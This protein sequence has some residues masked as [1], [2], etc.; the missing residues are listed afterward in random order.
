MK[1]KPF[2]NIDDVIVRLVKRYRSSTHAEQWN[3]GI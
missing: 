2:I 3:A 1:I